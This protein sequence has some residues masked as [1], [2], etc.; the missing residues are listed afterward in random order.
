MKNFSI[1]GYGHIGRVHQQAIEETENAQLISVIDFNLPEDLP[2]KGYSTLESFL[3]EDQETDVVVIA[4]PNGLHREHAIRCL[5]AGKNVL[6]EKPIALTV[7]DAKEILKVAEEKNLRVFTSM[8]L[9]FSP[10]VQ[11]VKN[12]ID[13]N[14]LGKVFMVNIN[15][16][17]NRNKNYYKLRE[18]HGNQ[19]MDGGV[20]FT[21]FSHFV[22][23]MNFWFDEVI[24]TNSK[25]FNFTHQEVTEF[26]DSGCVDF[27]ADGAIGHMIYTTS[28]FNKNF[29][30]NITLIAEKG[31][32][33]IGDQYLNQMIYSD[34]KN[35]CCSNKISTEQK[36]FHPNAIAEISDALIRH[37]ES[38]LDG[39]YAVNLV[40]FISDANH[41]ATENKQELKTENYEISHS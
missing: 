20:L 40:K 5:K 14:S 17:W 18:W 35:V 15:C 38:L 19:E 32:I 30:S 2:F 21:Q 34:L 26:D 28:V 25:S 24:C 22:D 8:Q 33:K 31:T 7:E 39:K 1:L 36:N 10:V 11:Y 9:R 23:I 16:Y 27:T 6:I 13:N 4:T 37:N 41:L 3:N 12:L 29:E